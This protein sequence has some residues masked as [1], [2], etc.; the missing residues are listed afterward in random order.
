MLASIRP[1]D[2][3][4]A[5]LV[6]VTGALVL[7]GALITSAAAA[8]LSWRDDGFAL[9]RL[10]FSVMLFVAFPAWIVMRIGAEWVYSKEGLDAL[11]PQPTWLNIGFQTADG[12]GLLLVIALILGGIGLRRRTQGRASGLLR[13]SGVLAAVLAAVYLIAVWAMGGKPT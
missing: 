2:I 8:V 1:H 3:D 12:G 6:H 7:V 10:S 13:L 5:L 11:H 4:L 9:A